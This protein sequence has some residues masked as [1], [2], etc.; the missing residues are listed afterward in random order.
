MV[1]LY[2]IKCLALFLAFVHAEHDQ[3]LPPPSSATSRQNRQV[4]DFFPVAG[5]SEL[6]PP[7]NDNEKNTLDLQTVA[8]RRNFEEDGKLL[9]FL[10]Y[11]VKTECNFVLRYSCHKQR[12]SPVSFIRLLSQWTW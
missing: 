3:E 6:V 1:P 8:D 10:V 9:L 12:T 11:S 5:D 2:T 7:Q 4:E